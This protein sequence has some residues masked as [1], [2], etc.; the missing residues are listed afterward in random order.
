MKLGL[1]VAVLGA[2]LAGCAGAPSDAELRGANYGQP[3]GQADAERLAAAYLAR[4]LKHPGSAVFEWSP[5][6][7]GWVRDPLITGG[8]LHFGYRLVGQVNAKNSFGGYTGRRRYEFILRDGA[9]RGA[10]AEEVGAYGST[11]AP[12]Y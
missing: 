8:E 2:S 1:F 7:P 12:M 11:M 6:A 9:V 5:V 10:W 4:R 3:I